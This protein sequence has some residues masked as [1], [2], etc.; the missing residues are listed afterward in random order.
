MDKI[1]GIYYKKSF[2]LLYACDIIHMCS[3]ENQM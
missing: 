3:R 1:F 2:I